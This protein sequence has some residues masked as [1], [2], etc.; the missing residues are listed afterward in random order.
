MEETR[1]P[2]FYVAH[3]PWFDG[4]G[5]HKVGQT[6]DLHRRLHDGAYVT[7]FPPGFRYVFVAETPTKRD[8]EKIEAGVLH[9]ARRA[10]V[11]R[12]QRQLR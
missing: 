8:A 7:C 5:L 1:V 4:A 11:Q 12:H 9:C 10:R 3:H 6:G 2:G